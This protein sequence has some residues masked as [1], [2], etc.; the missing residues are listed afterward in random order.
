MHIFARILGEPH[1]QLTRSQWRVPTS[2]NEARSNRRAGRDVPVDLSVCV[3]SGGGWY[4]GDVRRPTAETRWL[5]GEQ[6]AG[7]AM[8]ARSQQLP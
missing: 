6:L 3:G 2:V 4:E 1:A 5:R 8:S 7:P